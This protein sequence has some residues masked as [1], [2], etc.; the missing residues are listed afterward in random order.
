[1]S[2]DGRL[3]IALLAAWDG[4]CAWCRRAI[5]VTETQVDH[6]M[7]Q[8]L[9]GKNLADLLHA[10]ALPADYDLHATYNLVPACARCNRFKS[11][12]PAPNTPIIAFFLQQTRQRAP[13]IESHAKRL[14]SEAKIGYALA[15][16][17][18]AYPGSALTKAKLEEMNAATIVAEADI[19]VI[20]GTAVILH[21][22]LGA[23][24]NPAAWKV[25][26]DYGTGAVVVTDG[27]RTGYT[28]PNPAMTCW[29]CGSNGPWNGSRCLTC[30]ML[31]DGA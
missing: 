31:D 7:P 29:H 24:F 9:K 15:L 4:R 16:L 21:P 25:V 5:S 13:R 12:R 26:D 19:Q 18:D 30:G 8:T 11:D 28:S 23:L 27:Y 6:V 10:H 22:A 14:E 1:M 2:S 3:R 20:T 17:N